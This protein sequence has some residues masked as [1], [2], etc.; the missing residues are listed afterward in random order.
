MIS[1]DEGTSWEE[2][3]YCMY[4]GRGGSGYSGSV[5]LENDDILTVGA[6]SDEFGYP[7]EDHLGKSAL[8]A[9]RWQAV[10]D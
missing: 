5:T 6:V 4:F 2:D 10:K 8:W 7:W 9:I 1:R 3:V